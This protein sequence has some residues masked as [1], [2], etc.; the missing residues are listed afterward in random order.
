MF[1]L[2]DA[3]I[4][5]VTVLEPVDSSD[6]E[7]ES[8]CHLKV[9]LY[10]QGESVANLYMNT[11]INLGIISLN[12]RWCRSDLYNETASFSSEEAQKVMKLFILIYKLS[13]SET[14]PEVHDCIV[15]GN[16][17]SF[18]WPHCD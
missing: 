4:L 13:T 10:F 1:F 15:Y 16:S 7:G 18:G 2:L 3:K 6:R 14:V 12:W 8:C 17:K 9:G 11:A 5:Y